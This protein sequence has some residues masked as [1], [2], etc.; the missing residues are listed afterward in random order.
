ME[1][2]INELAKAYD[3]KALVGKLNADEN[4]AVAT[5]YS[6][7][8]LPTLL[9]FKGG[10]LVDKIVGVASRQMLE[11]MIDKQMDHPAVL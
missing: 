7:R 4:P 9:V 2:M 11:K 3:G 6:I 8:G 1:P 10:E 5:K